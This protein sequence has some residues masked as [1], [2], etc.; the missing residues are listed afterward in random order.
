MTLQLIPVFELEYSHPD[1]KSP[2]YPCSNDEYT[3]Y[4]DRVYELNGFV[5][6]F[7][8]I[9]HGYNLYSIHQTSENNLLKILND[10]IMKDKSNLD[11][12]FVLCEMNEILNPILTHR[13][14]S[15]FND[16]ESWLNL[17][18][19]NLKGFWIGH[20]MLYCKIENDQIRFIEEEEEE[21]ADIFINFLE[22]KNAVQQL[23]LELP[24][25]RERFLMVANKHQLDISKVNQFLKFTLIDQSN[26]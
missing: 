18:E 12:G 10:A 3:N 1:V 5:D 8:P 14:C 19:K 9:A 23:K 26:P 7:Q 11:G 22:F 15:D 17:A 16:V 24:K 6:K 2:P 4:L 25:I 13:C 21:L 20:P